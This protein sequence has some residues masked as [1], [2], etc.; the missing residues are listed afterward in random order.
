MTTTIHDPK[1]AAPTVRGRR[2]SPR[3]LFYVGTILSLLLIPLFF[4]QVFW[5]G[6]MITPWY[7]PIGGT[8]A[9]LMVLYSLVRQF[10]WWRLPVALVCVAIVCLEWQFLFAGSVLPAYKGPVG[11]G[12][13]L[14]AF[15]ANLADGT[16]D[17]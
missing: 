17:R 1:I 8:V 11:A 6:T 4:A 12:S 9:A 5:A 7:V 13:P 15:H 2:F 14:P 3:L 16:G 10:T